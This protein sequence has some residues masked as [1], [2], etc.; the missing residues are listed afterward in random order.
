MNK[1]YRENF[2]GHLHL[3]DSGSK[4]VEGKVLPKANTILAFKTDDVS[5][6][7]VSRNSA[8]FNRRSF[9]IYYYTDQPISS[10]QSDMPH[11]TLWLDTD[12]HDH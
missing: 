8:E 4:T 1:D 7:G 9:N 12:L 3:L 6:H 11:K 5:F 10:N 2:G